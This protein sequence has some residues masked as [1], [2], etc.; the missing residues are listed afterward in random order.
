MTVRE[1]GDETT[2]CDMLWYKAVSS[3]ITERE[4]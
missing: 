1:Y 4:L 3:N 2:S